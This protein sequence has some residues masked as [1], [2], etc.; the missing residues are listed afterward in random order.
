M[1]RRPGLGAKV[2]RRPGLGGE[3]AP[4]VETRLIG[5]PPGERAEPFQS[6][7]HI[8]RAIP[9]RA[10]QGAVLSRR[11]RVC[12]DAWSAVSSSRWQ[13]SPGKGGEVVDTVVTSRD[14]SEGGWDQIRKGGGNQIRT[15]VER[16]A[17][18]P[19]VQRARRRQPGEIASIITLRRC[20][21]SLGGDHVR[22]H[23]GWRGRPRF[24]PRS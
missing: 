18:T 16:R 15:A 3:V 10:N 20:P 9:R 24:R 2:A 22:I 19:V 14:R 4:A 12:Q 6:T 21:M 11:G 8:R 17:G 23:R 1:A 13:V 7:F 5:R